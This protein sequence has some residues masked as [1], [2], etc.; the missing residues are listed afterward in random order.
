MSIVNLYHFGEAPQLERPHI[1]QF[2][3]ELAE[4]PGGHD[5][6]EEGVLSIIPI[7]HGL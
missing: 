5:G 3:K 2:G 1:D 7:M 4:N 6:V